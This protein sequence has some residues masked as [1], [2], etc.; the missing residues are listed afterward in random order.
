MLAF[1]L[2]MEKRQL[3]RPAGRYI[4]SN[5]YVITAEGWEYV[6]FISVAAA[7]AALGPGRFSIDH[8]FG[9]MKSASPGSGQH[10][11]QR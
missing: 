9:S 11:W 2:V 3:E 7:L 6:R 1:L 4:S 10:P 5:Q 8:L